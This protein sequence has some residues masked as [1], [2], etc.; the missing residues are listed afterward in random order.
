ML[1][2]YAIFG[3]VKHD[4]EHQ[5]SKVFPAVPGTQEANG[6]SSAALEWH[7]LLKHLGVGSPYL[8]HPHCKGRH[9]GLEILRSF[10]TIM[11]MSYIDEADI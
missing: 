8:L 2:L 10:A 5:P 11:R 6:L 9:Q 7:A 1:N 3:V 4:W